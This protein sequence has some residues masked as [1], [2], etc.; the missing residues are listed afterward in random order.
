MEP[1][2]I[3]GNGTA[4]V[5]REEV[6]DKLQSLRAET[7]KI[8]GLAVVLVGE[9]KDSKA[10]VRMKRK[11]CDEA[12]IK[13]IH[14]DFPVTIS[15]EEL[16]NE[17]RILNED[18]EVDG[19]LI[20]LP[21][22][23]HIDERRVLEEVCLEKDVDGLHPT[24]TGLLALKGRNPFH[25]ACTPLGCIELLDRYNIPIEG[26]NAVVIGR[27][28]IVGVPVAMMLL[29]R[30]ATVTICH[31]RTQNLPEI[32]K[33]ADIVVAGVGKAEFVRGEWIKEGAVVL[34]V[35]FNH[36]EDPTAR[37][38]L[39]LCGDVNYEE[40]MPKCSYITPV[41]GGCGPMTIAMLIQ[42][43]YMSAKHSVGKQK[44]SAIGELIG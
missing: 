20:Q 6:R 18:P 2:V 25:Q 28:N 5:I 3:D 14:R 23:K 16:C 37:R 36:K 38:G 21:L 24:N 44:V 32:V 4:K 17:V 31:S 7:G 19:I 8:A 42:N 40:C 41:P 9:R 22:P 34:D 10:Y 43:T 13:S 1:V 12:G 26:K 33:Q 35:G 30:N 11:A 39:R 27:S 29:H 15:Q